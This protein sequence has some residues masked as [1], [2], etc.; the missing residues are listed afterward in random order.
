MGTGS[1]QRRACAGAAALLAAALG[2]LGAL[3]PP[4]PAARA[5]APP[6]LVPFESC[7]QLV[8]YARRQVRR[9]GGAGVPTRALGGPPQ[10]LAAPRPVPADGREEPAPAAQ[11]ESA[12]GGTG[13]PETPSFSGTNVQEAGVDEPDIVKTD[14]RR[15]FSVV[16][17]R[18]HVVDLTGAEP[19]LAGTLDLEGYGHALLLRGSRLLVTAE[20]E[21][22]DEATRLTEVDVTDPAAMAVRRT[23]DLEGRVV[24]SR[25][26]GGTARVVVA[27]S[28]RFTSPAA[29]R[30]GGLR[31][32]VPRT[33]LRSRVSG[34]TFRRSVA[35]CDDVRR[36][37]RLLRAR[38]A[39]RAHRRP[40]PRALLRRP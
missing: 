10:V 30:R 9:A 11:D 31:T 13:G 26:T 36:P 27:S 23:L 37:A 24:D 39:D 12:A 32:W 14:G 4:A 5:A 33:V 28:P 25:L 1:R 34:R 35:R 22:R 29:A 7:P 2:L 8:S 18:L 15:V 38:P 17:R 6:R 19:R 3:A 20:L 16:D 21:G 40:R